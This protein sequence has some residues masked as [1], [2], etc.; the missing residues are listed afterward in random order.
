MSRGES[1]A[2]AVV[3]VFALLLFLFGVRHLARRGFLLNNAYI[4]ATKEERDNMDKKPY[5]IQSGIVFCL[6]GLVF[7]LVGLSVVLHIKKLLIVEI[8]LI[9]GTVVYAIAS[10]IRINKKK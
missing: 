1:V 5:Y 7:T 9:A 3:F 8:V 6:L 2:A 4:Y 10:S